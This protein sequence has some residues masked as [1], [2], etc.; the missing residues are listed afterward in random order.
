MRPGE[1]LLLHPATFVLHA[2]PASGAPAPGR[3][4]LAASSVPRASLR[5]GPPTRGGPAG[6]QSGRLLADK[7]RHVIPPIGDSAE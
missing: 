1:L 7:G 3:V 4:R 2:R 5:L 6:H